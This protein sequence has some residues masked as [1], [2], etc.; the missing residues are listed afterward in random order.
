MNK[1]ESAVKIF[2]IHRSDMPELQATLSSLLT[3]QVDLLIEDVS[4]PLSYHIEKVE[5][6]QE[7]AC[8]RMMDSDIVLVLPPNK[9]NYEPDWDISDAELTISS[10]T[11]FANKYG[12]RRDR[13]YITELKNLM[14]D[15]C[16][17]KPVLVLGWSEE[18][19]EDL[20]DILRNPN[21]AGCGNNDAGRIHSMVINNSVSSE[22]LVLEIRNILKV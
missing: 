1:A 13:V 21:P 22:E 12:L 16:N 15:S 19:A 20:A 4:Y 10:C 11:S 14:Y 2:M 8:G 5:F 7:Y 9:S 6:I 18:E 3:S 17:N